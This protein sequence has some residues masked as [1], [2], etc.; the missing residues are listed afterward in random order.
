M[1]HI[2]TSMRLNV[3]HAHCLP[4]LQKG[5]RE[6]KP[7]STTDLQKNSSQILLLQSGAYVGPVVFCSQRWMEM[8]IMRCME[9]K[10]MT[11]AKFYHLIKKLIGWS[12][13]FFFVFETQ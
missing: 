1:L 3:D 6:F 12:D 11:C 7:L 13:N 10:C 5:S 8:R 4:A 9:G 2:L